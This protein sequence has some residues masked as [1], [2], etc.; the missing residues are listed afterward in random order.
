MLNQWSQFRH[1]CTG[2]RLQEKDQ[3]WAAAVV[4]AR[5][6]SMSAFGPR[7]H[8]PFAERKTLLLAQFM[9]PAKPTI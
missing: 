5:W 4:D 1:N 8:N 6:V 2:E 3:F 7:K 9:L